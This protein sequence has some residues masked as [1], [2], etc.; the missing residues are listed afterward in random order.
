MLTMYYQKSEATGYA[1][2]NKMRGMP[3][4]EMITLFKKAHKIEAIEHSSKFKAAG[5]KATSPKTP[6]TAQPTEQKP[7]HSTP[8]NTQN[9]QPLNSTP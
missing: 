9:Q 3:W 6:T 2:E 1:E 7:P 4:A 8:Y 5:T